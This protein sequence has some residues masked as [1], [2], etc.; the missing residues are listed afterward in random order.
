[1]FVE[2]IKNA[3]T[4]TI[5]YVKEHEK[6]GT[7]N[8]KTDNVTTNTTTLQAQD[9]LIHTLPEDKLV[10]AAGTNL[11]GN[12]NNGQTNNTPKDINVNFKLDLTSNNP[13]INPQDI[14]KA[15]SD[16][17]LQGKMVS[18]VQQGVRNMSGAPFGNEM[19]NYK[20]NLMLGESMGIS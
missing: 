15:L 17:G 9:L 3:T 18:A 11:D 13:N 16:T 6:L 5:G 8:S 12:N 4:A 19:S 2:L 14:I 1:M 20:N 10:L 7:D